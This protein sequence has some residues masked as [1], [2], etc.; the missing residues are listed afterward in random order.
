VKLLVTVQRGDPDGPAERQCRKRNRQ[1]AVEIVSFTLE[2]RVLLDVNDDV[3][4][5]GGTAAAAVFSF[6]RQ[7][8]TLTG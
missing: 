1:L 5:A 7:A 2:E 8:Q 6:A 4:V 3:E